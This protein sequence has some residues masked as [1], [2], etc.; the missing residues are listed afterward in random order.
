M[1]IGII[2]EGDTEYACLPT[3]VAKNEHVIVGTYNLGGVGDYFPWEALMRKKV[4]PLLRAFAYKQVAGRPDKV[5]IVI[6]R[7]KR[8]DCPPTLAAAGVSILGGCLAAENI[9][10]NFS[11]VVPDPVFE[12]WLLANVRALDESPFFKT[13]VS[14]VI[15]ATTDGTHML[16]SIKTCLKRGV[17]WDKVKFGKAL[18]QRLDI[19]NDTVLGASRSLRKFVKEI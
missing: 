19:R 16:K 18:A 10:M 8:V 4:Y 15:G 6:D 17:K 5:I 7:E 14:T 3:L 11:L 2:A 1:K 12:C 13:K 9:V